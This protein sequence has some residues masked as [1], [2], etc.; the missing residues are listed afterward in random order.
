MQPIQMHL[1]RKQ[2]AFSEFVYAFFE[3]TS[4]VEHFQKQ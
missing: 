4:N 2:N 1:S 3:S